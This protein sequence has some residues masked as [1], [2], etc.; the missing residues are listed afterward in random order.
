[1]TPRDTAWKVTAY[2][3][4]L[5]LITLVNYYVLAPLPIALPLLL[6]PAAVAAGTLEGSRFGAGFGLAAGL[7]FSGVGQASLLCVPAL[8][9][10]GWLSGLLTQRVLRRDLV[11]HLLC[12]L[13]VLLAWELCQVGSRLAAGTAEL[14][15][16]LKVAGPE[17][18]WSMVFA[19]PV[20]WAGLFCCRYY[21]RIYHE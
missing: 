1:M 6:P 14:V 16:L 11:G 4:A 8:A 7:L 18:L 3:V 5:A 21:G 19:F 15:P 9:L 20:Y 2:G 12:T 17:L 10:A 13:L